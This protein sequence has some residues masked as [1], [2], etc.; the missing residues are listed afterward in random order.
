VCT[1]ISISVVKVKRNLMFFF[2]FLQERQ[3]GCILNAYLKMNISRHN[4]NYDDDDD[5]CFIYHYQEQQ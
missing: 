1:P 5:A 3:L 4:N 2:V